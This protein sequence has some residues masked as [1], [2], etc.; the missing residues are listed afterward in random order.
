MIEEKLLENRIIFISDEINKH[1]AEDVMKKLLYLDSVNTEDIYIYINSVGG[2][3]SQG[4]AIIDCMHYVKSDV[5]TICTGVA[6]SM[7][8][9]ILASG[10]KRYSLPS[11]EIMIHQPLTS[12]RGKATEI[13]KSSQRINKVKTQLVQILS[14]R[15]KKDNKKILNDME[16][17]YFMSAEDAKKYGL[18]DQII[19]S[20]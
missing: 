5:I 1:T 17:D 11:G 16:D 7:G 14:N 19:L 8:A 18:I 9:V 13:E 6:Y 2:E 12:I 3:V 4:L 10:D 20:K 15:T